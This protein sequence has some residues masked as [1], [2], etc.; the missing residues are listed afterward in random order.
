MNGLQLAS[1]RANDMLDVLHYFFEDDLSAA[2]SEQSEA[3]S[4]A[5]EAIYRDLYLTEYK[6]ATKNASNTAGGNYIP[7]DFDEPLDSDEK[8]IVPFDPLKAPTKSF[9]PATKFNPDAVKPFG[10]VLDAPLER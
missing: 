5:R 6:Y 8:E 3:R 10:N 4:K 9:V 2:S 7:K 1:M